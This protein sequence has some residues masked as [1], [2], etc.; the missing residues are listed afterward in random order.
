MTKKYVTI[1]QLAEIGT[2]PFSK[3]AL[4]KLFR[5]NTELRERCMRKIKGSKMMID[6]EEFE[7]YIEEE[8]KK[9]V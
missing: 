3:S 4:Y 8:G 7:L 9:H 6:L 2:Y 1:N 5:D